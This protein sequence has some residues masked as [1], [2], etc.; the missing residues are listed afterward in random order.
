MIVDLLEEGDIEV[1]NKFARDLGDNGYLTS[2]E[3]LLYT[4]I[5]I[6]AA[7]DDTTGGEIGGI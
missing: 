1:P 6:I 5:D 4:A 3:F 7:A 2:S